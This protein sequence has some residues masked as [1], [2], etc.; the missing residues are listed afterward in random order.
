[1]LVF[2]IFIEKHIRKFSLLFFYLVLT[3]NSNCQSIGTLRGLITDST[4][5][6]VL[7]FC[8]VYIKSL[9]TGATTDPRGYFVISSIPSEQ[10]Y[11]V[12]F[13]YVGYKTKIDSIYITKNKVTNIDVSLNPTTY[14]T[15]QI[16][17]IGKDESQE[18]NPDL[19]LE[20]IVMKQL[21]VLPKGIETDILKSL[22]FLP[23]VRSTGDI[24]AKYYVRGGSNNQNLILLDGI[25][26]YNPFHALG[27]FSVIDAEIINNAEFYKGGFPAEFGGRISSVLS[28]I[29]KDGNKNK[30]SAKLGLSYISGKLMI[31]GPIPYGSFYLSGRKSY[32]TNMI[33][34]LNNEEKIPFDF[35]DAA[36]KINFSNPDF[37]KGSK[38]TLNGFISNDKLINE[39][40]YIEN[41]KWNN[42][43]FGFR[44]FQVG[45][46]PL[47][48]EINLSYS[49][50]LGEIIPNLSNVRPL[51][52]E[53]T[54]FSLKSNYNYIYDNN[55]EI[56]FGIHIK[57]IKT[58][59]VSENILGVM[60]D[61][62]KSGTIIS[63]FGKYKFMQFENLGIDL[64]TRVNLTRITAG[65]V[66]NNTFEPRISINYSLFSGFILKAAY[67]LYIQDLTTIS[68]EEQIITLLEPWIVTPDY[69]QPEKSTHYIIGAELNIFAPLQISVE[70]Y[71]KDISNLHAINNN[72]FLPNDR[73]LVDG[74]GKSYGVE[75]SIKYPTSILN[76]STAYSL[77]WAYKEVEGWKYYPKYDTKHTINFLFDIKLWYGFHLGTIFTFSSGLPFT[78]ISGYYDRLIIDDPY[79][80]DYTYSNCSPYTLLG[81][82]NLG[83]L[84]TYH[85]LDLS[86]TNKFE[87]SFLR[88]EAGISI[89][90]IYNRKNIFYYKKDTGERVNMLPFLLT[91]TLSIEI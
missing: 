23:G 91:G 77:A 43:L 34:K 87:I 70:G 19:G 7:A 76:I 3:I 62:G 51:K 1:M 12:I 22:Q 56:N 41:F 85:R 10:T 86:L 40:P 52:N 27:L 46:S 80:K 11:E 30:Y 89:L 35:Y 8:N 38:I 33:K 75:F 61:V 72:K 20:K 50:F 37:I 29:S 49:H 65:K 32:S 66:G 54:D 81:D 83:R 48:F 13:S 59:Y 58:K 36:F 17:I 78:Q 39:D 25:E 9:K 28:I 64:G 67:G 44:W 60:T 69:L 82:R 26:L 88:C 45:D 47:F 21:S 74:K 84:P 53:V 24:S 14:E 15:N 6:E 73:D 4:N 16:E 71:Y 63:A 42:E 55:N 31:E 5:G 68:D 90:N 18:N 57:D 2:Q 79:F